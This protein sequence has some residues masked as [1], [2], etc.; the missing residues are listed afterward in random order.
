MQQQIKY[1]QDEQ[2]K[3]NTQIVKL[4]NDLVN[5]KIEYSNVLSKN[6]QLI[7]ANVKLERQKN[8]MFVKL[9][10][11]NTNRTNIMTTDRSME[12]S[13][14]IVLN[15]SVNSRMS[16]TNGSIINKHV[17]DGEVPV[18]DR[19]SVRASNVG[20]PYCNQGFGN[21]SIQNRKSPVIGRP[22]LMTFSSLK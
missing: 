19:N 3:E 22:N 20:I 5:M 18:R 11:L 2:V 8:E 4:K 10:G 16:T 7:E 15:K 12:A 6:N 17:P 1:F 13:N 14:R 9:E 21:L